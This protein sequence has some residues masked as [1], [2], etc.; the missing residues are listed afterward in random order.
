MVGDVGDV[1]FGEAASGRF[2]GSERVAKYM[3]KG[4]GDATKLEL[5]EVSVEGLPCVAECCMNERES[6]FVV[7][8]LAEDDES[9]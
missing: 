8:K 3:V 9:F 7:V 1:L 4:E 2:E 5:G 6:K